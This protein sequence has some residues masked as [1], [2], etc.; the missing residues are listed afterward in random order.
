M[1]G[2]NEYFKSMIDKQFA[3]RDELRTVER[4]TKTLD[5][6]LRHS[7][8]YKA[9]RKFKAKYDTLYAE[10]TTLKKATGFGAERKAQKALDTAN[11]FY[12]THCNEITMYENAERYLRDVLQKHYDPMK[13]PPIVKWQAER[14]SLTADLKRLN[15]DYKK[16]K[17]DTAKVEK[18]RS[19]VYDI[20]RSESRE[21]QRTRTQFIDL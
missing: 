12:E 3:I 11:E 1:D 18:I 9:N 21:T 15:L 6:H 4:R 5:E 8:N 17:D 7:G 10:Y 19:N 2:I 14:E 20:L 13:L 16:L